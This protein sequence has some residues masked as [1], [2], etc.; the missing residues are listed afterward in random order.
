[1]P[2]LPLSPGAVRKLL[3]E[4]ESSRAGEHV[5]AVGG[6]DELARVLRQQFL[7]GRA[8]PRRSPRG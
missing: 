7:R 1:M 8:E 4:M 2:R 3:R 6:T 5:L